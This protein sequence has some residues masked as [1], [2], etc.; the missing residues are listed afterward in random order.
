MK[1]IVGLGNPGTEY[2]K[3]RH[4]AGFMAVER[5]A[6]RHTISGV[7]SNFHAG[8]LDGQVAGHRCLLVQPMTFMNRS[9]LTVSEAMNFYKLDPEDLLVIVDEVALDVG[10]IRLRAT[11]SAGG[12]NGLKDIEAKLG[13]ADYPRLRI[14]VGSP[15]RA[16]RKD[17]VLGRFTEEQLADL[18]PALDRT[19]DCIESWLN[20]GIEKTMSLY[21]AAE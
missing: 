13:T 1:L 21:N 5:L 19:C 2:I 18:S 6:Q 20:D 10:T 12:H 3:T 17:F 11:G 16:A 15:T 4:N 7:K 14:G 8:V 9:G